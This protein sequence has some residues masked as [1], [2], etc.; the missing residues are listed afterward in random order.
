MK[1]IKLDIH[2][3]TH[4]AF[5]I[6]IGYSIFIALIVLYIALIL[7]DKYG[8]G[9]WISPIA[10]FGMMIQATSYIL[11]GDYIANKLFWYGKSGGPYKTAF[12]AII[13]IFGILVLTFILIYY[14]LFGVG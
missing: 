12:F 7:P 1:M 13:S 8:T 11:T 10:S 2:N 14:A 5:L 6:S 4:L 3:K 9:L